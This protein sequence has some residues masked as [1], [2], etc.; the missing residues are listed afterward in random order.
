MADQIEINNGI[1]AELQKDAADTRSGSLEVEKGRVLNGMHRNRLRAIDQLIQIQRMT[2][3]TAP[4]PMIKEL[5]VGKPPDG[6]ES[7]TLP[8]ATEAK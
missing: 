2:K 3:Q 8:A 6:S 1:L 5:I 4:I 7:S